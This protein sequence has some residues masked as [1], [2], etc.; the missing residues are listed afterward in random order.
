MVS[1][2]LFWSDHIR[3][4]IF[5]LH[6]KISLHTRVDFSSLQHHKAIKEGILWSM[7][8]TK[9]RLLPPFFLIYGSSQIS[10]CHANR[11][12]MLSCLR[13]PIHEYIHWHPDSIII[14][15]CP[16]ITSHK[17]EKRHHKKTKQMTTDIWQSQPIYIRMTF[18]QLKGE[19]VGPEKTEAVV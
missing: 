13:Q 8:W 10:Y 12:S 17:V 1:S 6:V 5:S 2:S 14:I 18:Q 19:W 15:W 7:F 4:N 16:I 9:T 3:L 11:N